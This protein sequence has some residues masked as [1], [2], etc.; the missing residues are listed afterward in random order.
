MKR[1]LLVDSYYLFYRSHYAMVRHPLINSKGEETSVIV[2]FLNTLCA[3]LQK[4]VYDWVIV[5]MDSKKKTF[6]HAAYPEYKANRPPMPQPLRDQIEFLIPLIEDMGLKIVAKPGFEA[7]DLIATYTTIAQQHQTPITTD[8]FAN[9]KDITQ[10]I[11]PHTSLIS[12][13]KTTQNIIE[14][15]PQSIQ[16]RYGLLPQQ[17]NDYLALMGD[18]SDN[19]P[20]VPGV[21]KVTASALIKEHHSLENLY[22]NLN[23]VTPS[24]LQK[25]LSQHKHLAFLSKQLTRLE[26]KI[27]DLSDLNHMHPSLIEFERVH[28][29][30]EQKECKQIQKRFFTPKPSQALTLPEHLHALLSKQQNLPFQENVLLQSNPLSYERTPIQSPADMKNVVIPLCQK[31]QCFAFDIE[32]TSLDPYDAQMVAIVIVPSKERSFYIRFLTHQKNVLSDYLPLLKSLLEDPQI[33]KIGHH[34]KFE[35]AVL[36]QRYNITLQGPLQDTLLLEYLLHPIKNTYTLSS[37]VQSTFD[38]PKPTYKEL[39]GNHASILDIPPKELQEYTFQDGE[40]TYAIHQKQNEHLQVLSPKTQAVYHTIDMPLTPILAQMELQGVCLDSAYLKQ[41]EDSMH[42]SLKHVEQQII[43]LAGQ[44]FNI[45][46]TKQLQKVLFTDLCISPIRKT[47]TGYSTDN[48][49]LQ[50]LAPK[51]EIAAL[52]LQQ[53]HLAKLLNTYITVLPKLIHPKTKRLHTHYSQTTTATGRLSSHDPNLQNIPIKSKEG[54][55]IRQAF[56]CPP[57]DK[58]VSLDYSQ[59]ELR[60]LA[61]LS[62][63]AMLLHAYSNEI[64]IHL[65]TA[66]VLFAVPP[67]DLQEHHRRIAKT[68]NFSVIYGVSAYTLAETLSLTP[69]EAK[70][71]IDKYFEFYP[72]VKIFRESIL[73]QARQTRVVETHYGRQRPV[74]DILS[75][76]FTV[77]SHAERIA[78]NSVIQG[79]AADVIKIAMQAIHRAITTQNLPITMV[80]QIH[81]ELVFYIPEKDLSQTVSILQGLMQ[82]IKPFESLLQV[83]TTISDHLE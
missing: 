36:K 81:D 22:A 30:L 1:L 42:Q 58:V 6:R 28:Q 76:N 79:T 14:K 43:E 82:K 20:G 10:V 2:G 73:E 51:H 83:K 29:K 44:P 63:D 27:P 19:V 57:N 64:D 46:S 65:Q 60:I 4:R 5:T 71:F 8:I 39:L 62:Q 59:V 37:I 12:I 11:S 7:D 78:F 80:M 25:K 53:R 56:I 47:K 54:Q 35:Y 55:Q 49:V 17:I 70:L 16:E 26:T 13:D 38:H 18:T 21:G 41:L 24:S 32:T 3:L 40:Y 15:T 48:K 72:K 67:H 74:K 50:R 34:L 45:S 9:D 61:A 75:Q 66:K 69:H 52:I 33:Q 23:H 31:T 77:R 68:V